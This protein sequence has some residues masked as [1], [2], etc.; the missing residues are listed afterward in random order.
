MRFPEENLFQRCYSQGPTT[1]IYHKNVTGVYMQESY[2]QEEILL[3][4]QSGARKLS[5][6]NSVKSVFQGHV[7]HQALVGSDT[8]GISESKTYPIRD[9]KEGNFLPFILCD[10]RGPGDN[11]G[12]C[13]GDRVCFLKGYIPDRYQTPAKSSRPWERTETGVS[14]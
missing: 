13:T 1:V 10:S 3:L 8:S 6:F 7:T 2:Q 14:G 11:E 4:G 12:P 9:G 5:F